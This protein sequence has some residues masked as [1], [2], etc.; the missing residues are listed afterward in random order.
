M[1]SY[2]Y[3]PGELD[4]PVNEFTIQR[5]TIVELGKLP[6]EQY[7]CSRLF[8]NF[9]KQSSTELLTH[10]KSTKR[11]FYYVCGSNANP[12]KLGLVFKSVW[13]ISPKDAWKKDVKLYDQIKSHI[14]GDKNAFLICSAGFFG[15]I[16]I[17]KLEHYNNFLLNVGSVYDPIILGKKTRGY[18]KLNL[19]KK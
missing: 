10:I 12:S 17:S 13:K 4:R 8:C 16:I 18:Q 15:N 1:Q 7:T 2:T 6:R 11:N 3:K 9:Y 14:D 19:M 5:K